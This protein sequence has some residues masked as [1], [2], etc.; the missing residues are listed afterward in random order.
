MSCCTPSFGKPFRCRLRRQPLTN[1]AVDFKGL[2]LARCFCTKFPFRRIGIDHIGTRPV[3]ELPRRD[4]GECR[5]YAGVKFKRWLDDARRFAVSAVE[6]REALSHR[7]CADVAL[8]AV[9]DTALFGR[10]AM[11]P[12]ELPHR[13]QDRHEAVARTRQRVLDARRLLNEIPSRDQSIVLQFPEMLRQHFLRDGRN[14][15]QELRG[16]HRRLREQSEQ[17]RQLPSSADH[18]KHSGYM[19]DRS[20]RTEAN[21]SVF[22]LYRHFK[23]RN[24]LVHR[25]AL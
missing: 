17:D 5:G 15:P 6:L 1:L 7:W 16:P 23:V 14:V 10:P 2:N 9:N 22:I 20:V 8:Q 11:K 19:R 25:P 13:H 12:G 18:P 3:H 4:D 21:L 24:C